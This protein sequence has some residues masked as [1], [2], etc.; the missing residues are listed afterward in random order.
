MLAELSVLGLEVRPGL[1]EFAEADPTLS[2]RTQRLAER[3]AG[4]GQARVLVHP[5]YGP[6]LE[7]PDVPG[8]TVRYA[9]FA[10]EIG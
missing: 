3:L 2:E 9:G 4:Q 7:F 8:I 5:A 10:S 1:F 6:F